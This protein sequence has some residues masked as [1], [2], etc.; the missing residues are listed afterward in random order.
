[1]SL[2]SDGST[3]AVGGP[4]DGGNDGATWTFMFDGTRYQQFG[5]KL[6]GNGASGP[7]QLQGKIALETYATHLTF[8]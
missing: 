3:L 8:S 7:S 6:V 5:H 2:S 4:N 1:M